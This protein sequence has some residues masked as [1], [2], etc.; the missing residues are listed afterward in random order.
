V[1]TGLLQT[2]A[3]VE[4]YGSGASGAGRPGAETSAETG[5]QDPSGGPLPPGIAQK[6]KTNLRSAVESTK[7]AKNEP[8]NEP[9]RTRDAE[10]PASVSLSKAVETFQAGAT[11]K[12]N[13]PENE[14]ERPAHPSPSILALF[15]NV[16]VLAARAWRAKA[17]QQID[18]WQIFNEEPGQKRRL[19][20]PAAPG[21]YC[22]TALQGRFQAANDT[23]TRLWTCFW[24]WPRRVRI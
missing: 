1:I 11:S 2:P 12:A 5:A 21:F 22:D 24:L 9:E 17:M 15:W 18:D 6:S 20:P 13:E 10:G 19:G 16:I 14:P 8:E 3:Y 7:T 4:Q 23:S